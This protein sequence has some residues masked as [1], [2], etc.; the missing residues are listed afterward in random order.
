MAG[1]HA[2]PSVTTK[3]QAVSWSKIFL[4]LTLLPLAT[5]VLMIF[6]W[7][8]DLTVFI[9]P[10][11]QLQIGILLILLAFAAANAAQ[12]LWAL[13]SAWLLLAIADFLLVVWVHTWVQIIALSLAGI[14]VFL[15]G[16]QVYRRSKQNQKPTKKAK[17][18]Q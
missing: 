1:K 3:R 10:E 17:T 9:S 7:A 11:I 18:A 4:A 14:G 2:Y 6:G 8:M 5:G 16:M 13:A 12:K 15:L